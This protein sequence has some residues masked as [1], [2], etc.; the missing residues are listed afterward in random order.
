MEGNFK[1]VFWCDLD[2]KELRTSS[3]LERVS[4]AQPCNTDAAF[5]M[6]T[7]P[8]MIGHHGHDVTG[9]EANAYP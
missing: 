1:R 7:G 9:K 8:D 3:V 5:Q 6:I 4:A 2:A